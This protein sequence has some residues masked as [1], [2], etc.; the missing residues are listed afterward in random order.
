MERFPYE[1]RLRELGPFSTERR[2][3]WGD[4]RA[5]CQD[6]QWGYER[7]GGRILSRVCETRQGKWFQTNR[8]EI[9]IG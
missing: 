1:D 6:L 7:E 9:D 3:L 5:A 4:L 8:G 2:R